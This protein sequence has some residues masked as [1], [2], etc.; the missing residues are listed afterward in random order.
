V[1]RDL[2]LNVKEQRGG[3]TA[4]TLAREA[5]LEKEILPKG[6]RFN[7]QGENIYWFFA[8]AMVIFAYLKTA[9][10]GIVKELLEVPQVRQAVKTA[11]D[12]RI[13]GGLGCQIPSNL[14]IIALQYRYDNRPQGK[15]LMRFWYETS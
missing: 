10:G 8:C 5:G 14:F 13:S 15:P 7:T 9:L 1:D 11:T 3:K 2:Q 12:V 6:K 4:E